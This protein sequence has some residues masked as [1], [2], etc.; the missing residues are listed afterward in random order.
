MTM[1]FWSQGVCTAWWAMC[2]V[3]SPATSSESFLPVAVSRASRL[4]RVAAAS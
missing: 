4:T 1:P 2:T 3:G